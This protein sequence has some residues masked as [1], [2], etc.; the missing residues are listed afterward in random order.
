MS[1]NEAGLESEK[2]GGGKAF[3]FENHLKAGFKKYQMLV[4]LD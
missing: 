1:A 3:Y 2:G 4:S